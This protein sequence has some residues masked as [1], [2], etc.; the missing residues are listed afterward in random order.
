M[1]RRGFVK[2]V[3]VALALLLVLLSLSSCV[4]TLGGK[5]DDYM[6]REE[7]EELLNSG[8]YGEVNIESSPNY[9]ITI[10]GDV[11]RNLQAAGKAVLSAVS[12]YASFDFGYSSN[13]SAGAGVIYKL[14]KQK[15]DAYIITN[16][17][18]VFDTRSSSVNM[19]SND[20]TVRLYGQ[21][22][23]PSGTYP[24]YDIPATFIGGSLTHDLAILKVTG[25]R[26]LA[27]S[28]CLPVSV[29]NSDEVAI[30]DTAIAVGNPSAE[31]I[32]ATL[33][34]INVD[35]EYVTISVTDNYPVTQRLFRIDTAVNSGN[36]GGG[37]FNDKGELIGIVNAKSASSSVEN[38]GYAIPSNVVKF[39]SDNIID[40]C[41]GT[42]EERGRKYLLGITLASKDLT[43]VYDT[44]SGR[45][46]KRETV[47]IKSIGEGT[48]AEELFNI[49]DVINF[50]TIDGERYDITRMYQVID[51]MF[52]VRANSTVTINVTGADGVAVNKAIDI[53]RLTPDIII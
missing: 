41:D 40:H 44:E 52:S 34:C 51:C 29:A 25:S 45:V 15:G 35:S 3:A 43:T 49:G 13:T 12:V 17:H 48:L 7:V 46:H 18:V 33:G 37:L 2:I 16:Y 11:N 32:S 22:D 24:E 10:D 9:N 8:I 23:S 1:K 30:L 28:N 26:V 6:T 14:D 47:Y 20:I 27:E 42:E 19:V 39:V 38:V 31:G 36:S 50:I 4:L 5:G 21:E 53:S